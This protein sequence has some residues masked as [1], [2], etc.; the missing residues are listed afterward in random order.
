MVYIMD[1]LVDGIHNSGCETV[2]PCWESGRW[3]KRGGGSASGES[4]SRVMIEVEIRRGNM[5]DGAREFMYG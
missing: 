1:D 5:Y 3:R 4:V 2:R